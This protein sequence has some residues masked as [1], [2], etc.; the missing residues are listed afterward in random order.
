[1]NWYKK[2]EAYSTDELMEHL[3]GKSLDEL[4]AIARKLN[5]PYILSLLKERGSEIISRDEILERL[6]TLIGVSDILSN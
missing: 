2:S 1:M 3:R 6:E 5:E 4:I